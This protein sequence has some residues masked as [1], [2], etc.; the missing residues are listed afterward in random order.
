MRNLLLI[1]IVFF[2]FWVPHSD[3]QTTYILDN[4]ILNSRHTGHFI[5][6]CSTGSSSWWTECPR[7][8]M[9][10]LISYYIY[11]GI[12]CSDG[13]SILDPSIDSSVNLYNKYVGQK[14]PANA[15]YAMCA[16]RDGL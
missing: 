5:G 12:D 2:F 3:A 4:S 8:S 10:A 11:W 14:D 16:L 13:S 15:I 6:A 7:K 1:L 9:F